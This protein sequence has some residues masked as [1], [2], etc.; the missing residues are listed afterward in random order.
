LKRKV[1]VFT[2]FCFLFNSALM[3]VIYPGTAAFFSKEA[4]PA[5]GVLAQADQV[6]NTV[7]ALVSKAVPLYPEYKQQEKTSN[8]QDLGQPIVVSPFANLKKPI[9]NSIRL[10]NYKYGQLQA[11]LSAAEADVGRAQAPPGA[12]PGGGWVL[13]FVLLYIISLNRSN[14]PAVMALSRAQIRPITQ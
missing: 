4:K 12:P 10:V 7:K 3:A 13:L 1:G 2:L 11:R 6:V 8:N 14:L 5:C 9:Q